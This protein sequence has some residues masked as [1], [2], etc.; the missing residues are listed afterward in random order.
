MSEGEKKKKVYKRGDVV[1]F[2]LLKK[3]QYDD[4]VL[5]LLNESNKKDTLNIEIIEALKLYAAVK[6][7]EI[8][9]TINESDLDNNLEKDSFRVQPKEYNSSNEEECFEEDIFGTSLTKDNLPNNCYEEKD[10]TIIENEKQYIIQSI[11]NDEAADEVF[12]TKENEHIESKNKLN[13][14]FRSLR[15]EI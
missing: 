3:Q 13:R 5:K 9:S 6:Y 7:N 4:N 1:T 12:E 14:A 15:R 11:E 10:N 8:R 2:R